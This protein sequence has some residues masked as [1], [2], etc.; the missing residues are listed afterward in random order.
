MK[1]TQLH[2]IVFSPTGTSQKIAAAISG[3]LARAGSAGLPD[4]GIE[5][6]NT[7][8]SLPVVTVDLTHTAAPEQTLPA[9]TIA[10][11]AVPVYGGHVAPTALE[12]MR[13]L[14]GRGTPAVLAVVYG[15]RAFDGAL[16]ELAAFVT[17]R[18]FAPVAAG[19]FVGEHSYSTSATPIAAGRP[20]AEDLAQAEAFGQAVGGKM[21][22]GTLA[23]IDAARLKTPRTPFL[24][25]LRFIRFVLGYRRRQKRRPVVLLPQG[26]AA[27]CTHCGHCAEVCPTQAIAPG[28]ELRTDPARCIRCNACVKACPAGSRT[29]PAPFAAT[30]SR[31]FARRKP[32]V[33][34]L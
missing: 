7:E 24:S 14:H 18:G 12:R 6:D 3:G 32:P 9:D 27:S 2:S 21:A 33:V 31:N 11:F 19:A 29:F 26:D 13:E 8:K 30:L 4:A 10:L 22:A 25:Q 15:N 5:P 16:R 1:P 20:D 17:E 34:L 23:L 28:D